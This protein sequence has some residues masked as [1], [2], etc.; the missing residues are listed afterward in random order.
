M[1]LA[2][3]HVLAKDGSQYHIMCRPG[4][5]GRYVLLPGDPAR[6]DDIASRL[7]GAR[8]IASNREHRTW[9]GSVAG[10]AVSA[11]STGMGGP[12]A[13]IAVEELIHCGAEV[14]IRVG[15][16]G[17]MGASK[18]PDVRA[19][20]CTGAIRDEG[21]TRQYAP[22]ELPAIADVSITAALAESARELG[23]RAVEGISRC[24]D[25]FYG[26]VDPGS[27]PCGDELARRMEIWERC[28][29]V[30]DE[31]ESAAIFVVASIRGARAGSILSFGDTSDA[32]LCALGAIARLA[33]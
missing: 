24:K 23:I 14:F 11:T 15:T 16:A 18:D 13:A 4:D 30:A 3:K 10:T 27:M 12:S 32:I 5:V 1:S 26:Q 17:R 22:I 31:M 25:S 9:T 29:A 6:A 8:L 28:G 19:A 21:T 7:D 20:I 2:S 33:R